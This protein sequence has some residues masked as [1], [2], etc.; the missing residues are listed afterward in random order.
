M[1][2]EQV[3]VFWRIKACLPLCDWYYPELFGWMMTCNAQ[4]PMAVFWSLVSPLLSTELQRLVSILPPSRS[5]GAILRLAPPT[6]VPS[7]YGGSLCTLPEEEIRRL[8]TLPR[9]TDYAAAYPNT[10][11]RWIAKAI[12]PVEGSGGPYGEV[13]EAGGLAAPV[14]DYFAGAHTLAPSS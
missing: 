9:S 3:R 6:S 2:S 10:L 13:D 7:C 4:G 1:Y 5:Y 11:G 14:W 8:P 12:V